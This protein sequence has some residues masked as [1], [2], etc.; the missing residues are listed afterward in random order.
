MY[1]RAAA[2]VDQALR[3]AKPVE[4]PVEQVSAFELTINS[5]TAQAMGLTIPQHVL[6]QTTAVVQ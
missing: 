5:K 6:A 3:G 1:R 4:L 2:Y